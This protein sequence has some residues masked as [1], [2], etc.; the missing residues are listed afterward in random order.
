MQMFC[1]SAELCMTFSV[2]VCSLCPYALF[3]QARS[4]FIHPLWL[5]FINVLLLTHCIIIPYMLYLR[6][7]HI[8][9]TSSVM[10][11]LKMEHLHNYVGGLQRVRTLT[12]K[13]YISTILGK[14]K[15]YH[16]HLVN[17]ISSQLLTSFQW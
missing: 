7:F 4:Q 1:S 5:N 2:T 9:V 6:H 3:L 10:T 14:T 12:S 11:V 15:P 16:T 8:I 13:L 17:P